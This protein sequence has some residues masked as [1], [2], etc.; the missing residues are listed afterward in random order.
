MPLPV[1]D[2]TRGGITGKLLPW[3]LM[4]E[5]LNPAVGQN[6]QMDAEDATSLFDDLAPGGRFYP[7][8]DREVGVAAQSRSIPRKIH[9][10]IQAIKLQGA[11]FD[12]LDPYGS[13]GCC[14]RG[15]GGAGVFDPVSEALVH[16]PMVDSAPLHKNLGVKA[17]ELSSAGPVSRRD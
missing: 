17:L 5:E 12:P 1:I 9:L 10:I 6:D 15:S 2:Q 13:P 4:H 14:P 11:P 7:G 3:P 16:F 8:G